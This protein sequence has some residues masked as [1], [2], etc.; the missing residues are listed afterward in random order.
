MRC[1]AMLAALALQAKRM[2]SYDR[3][4]SMLWDDPIDSARSNL[5]SM[6]T[7]IRSALL[8]AGV[9]S[10]ISLRTHRAARGGTGGYSL[11]VPE[12]EVDLLCAVRLKQR[13]KEL[14]TSDPSRA[15]RLCERALAVNVGSLGPDLP[16]TLWFQQQ[17]ERFA[18]LHDSLRL[19]HRC[20]SIMVGEY[21][22]EPGHLDLDRQSDLSSAS[23]ELTAVQLYCQGFVAEALEAIRQTS[24][25][26]RELGLDLPDSSRQIQMEILNDNKSAVIEE[27]RNRASS[28]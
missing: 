19:L 15:K 28:I 5:R 21:G 22:E 12:D 6:A 1:R 23:N 8:E 11:A 27:V 16:S 25:R 9:A 17:Q 13:A 7:G 14:I 10:S 18:R 24:D 2:I 3:L 4:A 26:Y 20:L